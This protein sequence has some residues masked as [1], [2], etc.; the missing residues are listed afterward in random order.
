MREFRF[1][2]QND[3]I[4]FF[5]YNVIQAIFGQQFLELYQN[6]CTFTISTL[7]IYDAKFSFQ[8]QCLGVNRIRLN[9]D[10]GSIILGKHCVP[11]GQ[12]RARKLLKLLVP[13][14]TLVFH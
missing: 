5:Q 6:L 4:F 8:I 10:Y 12:T 11:V 1:I 14:F 2:T 7:L 3:D 9:N 13:I